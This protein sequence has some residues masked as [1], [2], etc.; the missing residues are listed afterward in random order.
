MNKKVE[1]HKNISG[2]RR[3]TQEG[4]GC[5]VRRAEHEQWVH[6]LPKSHLDNCHEPSL[7]PA[8]HL[9][10][11]SFFFMHEKRVR[12]DVEDLKRSEGIVM[13]DNINGR[14]ET[15]TNLILHLIKAKHL[16]LRNP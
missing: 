10:L 1:L 8:N 15:R 12:N 13:P 9:G 7:N 4:R 16:P 6:P 11:L 2:M 5:E 3:R 14:K